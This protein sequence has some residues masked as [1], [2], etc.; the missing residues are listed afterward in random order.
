MLNQYKLFITCIESKF[1]AL[2]RPSQKEI[3]FISDQTENN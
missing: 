3:F 1:L 2:A